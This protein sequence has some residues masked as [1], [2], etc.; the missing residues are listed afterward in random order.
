[1]K[2]IQIGNITIGDGYPTLISMEAGATHTGLSSAKTLAKA[3][4]SGGADAI[5]FQTVNADELISDQSQM[6]SFINSEGETMQERV[7]DALKR[8]ELTRDE[9]HELK[10][11][12]DELDLLFISTPFSNECVDILVEIKAH[13]IKIAKSDINHFQLVDYVA[14][15]G[16]PIILDGRER[17]EDVETCVSIC[18]KHDV[19][20][21]VIMHC[22]SGY[23]AEHSGIHLS[24]I[25]HIRNIFGYPAGYSDHSVGTIMNYAAI[26]LGADMVE[27]TV[28]LDK[29]TEAVEHSMSL[30]PSEIKG[31]VQS[32]RDVE[33]ALG[34]PRIIFNSRVKPEARRSIFAA[35]KLSIGETIQLED[36]AFRRPGTYFSAQNYEQVLG[37]TLKRDVE[38]GAPVMRDDLNESLPS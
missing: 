20:D 32:I 13:A 24:A 28:T 15:Q 21:L 17:F 36:L 26:A 25:P 34:D 37:C 29:H 12:C 4:A 6:I 10:K 14:Q 2:N 35:R 23:P 33:N 7:Y 3:V 30:E 11:Y 16:L 9:W 18:E 5:K 8:R 38:S 1:V 31:F 19:K 22:P 27:K